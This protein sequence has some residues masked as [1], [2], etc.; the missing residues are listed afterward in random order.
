MP[1]ISEMQ[2]QI[3][4]GTD[5]DVSPRYPAGYPAEYIRWFPAMVDQGTT[6]ADIVR[7]AEKK[8]KCSISEL[9][10]KPEIINDHRDIRIATI[11]I[12]RK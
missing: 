10:V 7:Q 11:L 6:L 3:V 2:L 12:T 9:L 8:F 4:D 1:V 5:N